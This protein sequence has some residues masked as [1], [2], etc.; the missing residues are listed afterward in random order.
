[1][2][3]VIEAE[4]PQCIDALDFVK[5]IARSSATILERSPKGLSQSLTFDKE[6]IKIKITK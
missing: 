6:G 1:M 4:Y 5:S 3:I 2:K